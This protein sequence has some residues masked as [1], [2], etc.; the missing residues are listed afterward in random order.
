ME[1]KN[2]KIKSP[3]SAPEGY[4]ESFEDKLLQKMQEPVSKAK[5]T[6]THKRPFAEWIAAAAAVV[7]IAVS[8]WFVL[9]NTRNNDVPKAL[10]VKTS[11]PVQEVKPVDSLKMQPEIVEA[12]LYEAVIE[13]MEQPTA[14]NK[15]VVALSAADYKTATELEDAGLLVLDIED[16]L[17]DEFEL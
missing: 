2:D 6:V 10:A 16:G 13:E 3:Y 12:Q 8:A 5:L 11:V 1:P 15:A 7:A 17:F 9:N 14:S 4:F